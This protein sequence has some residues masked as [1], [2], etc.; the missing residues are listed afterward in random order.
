MVCY[1]V[2]NVRKE[3]WTGLV[4]GTVFA[5]AKLPTRPGDEY[6]GKGIWRCIHLRWK[7]DDHGKWHGNDW[8]RRLL[9]RSK[10]DLSLP[11]D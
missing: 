6:T 10:L 11:G 4:T 7:M 9:G 5:S 1:G 8:P 3:A 2:Q